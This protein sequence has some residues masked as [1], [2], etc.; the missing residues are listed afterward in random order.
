MNANFVWSISRKG[1]STKPNLEKL[2][3]RILYAKSHIWKVGDQN[4]SN[5]IYLIE[6]IVPKNHF[7][8]KNDQMDP[9]AH[10]IFTQWDSRADQF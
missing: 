4:E 10:P 9:S 5:L 3:T 7:N 1:Y 2:G 6:K 8:L